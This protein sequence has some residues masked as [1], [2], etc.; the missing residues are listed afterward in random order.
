MFGKGNIKNNLIRNDYNDDTYQNMLQQQFH[1][2]ELIF[3]G[4]LATLMRE[5]EDWEDWYDN[6]SAIPDYFNYGKL[7]EMEKLFQLL[8]NRITEVLNR[9]KLDTQS[10]TIRQT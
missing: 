2:N 5:D 9:S 3:C 6:R 8:N 1:L 10:A 7:K 4:L